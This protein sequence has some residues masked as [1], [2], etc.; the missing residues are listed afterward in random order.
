MPC[1]ARSGTLRFDHWLQPYARLQ[2]HQ[3]MSFVHPAL[4]RAPSVRL[5]DA[6]R[7]V[8]VALL[9]VGIPFVLSNIAVKLWFP[10]GASLAPLRNGFKTIVLIAAY[11]GYVRW[12]EK[13]SPFE[14]S[15]AGAL[16]ETGIGLLIGASVISASVAVL[17]VFDAP[18][19]PQVSAQHPHFRQMAGLEEAGF[20]LC[21]FARLAP[22]SSPRRAS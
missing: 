11:L 10:D 6:I 8:V 1:C 7:Q 2:R 3:W 16:K 17:A 5:R 15:L 18:M 13:R 20:F 14:L 19:A 12:V 4:A 22:P 9:C 21:L